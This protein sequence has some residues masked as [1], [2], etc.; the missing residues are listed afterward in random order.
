MKSD[1][2][3]LRWIQKQLS[4]G[5]NQPSSNLKLLGLKAVKEQKRCMNKAQNSTQQE[6]LSVKEPVNNLVLIAQEKTSKLFTH[7]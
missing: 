3:Q 2:V 5:E 7:H 4:L 1:G 6:L